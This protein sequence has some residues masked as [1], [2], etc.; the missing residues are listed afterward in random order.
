M[1]EPQKTIRSSETEFFSE[2]VKR[3]IIALGVVVKCPMTEIAIP[4]KWADGPKDIKT[5]GQIFTFFSPGRSQRPSRPM[6][7]GRNTCLIGFPAWGYQS[8]APFPND[9]DFGPKTANRLP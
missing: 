9:Q 1:P 3:V 4:K 8:F 7:P 2:S 5:L 6:L